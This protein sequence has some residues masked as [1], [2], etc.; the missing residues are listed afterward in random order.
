MKKQSWKKINFRLKDWGVSRQRYWGCPIPIAYDKNGKPKKIPKEM[1][2][3]ELPEINTLDPVGNPLD[4]KNNWKNIII[5]GEN[6]TRET[7]TLDTFVDSSWYFLRF[8]SP[9]KKNYGFDDEA[10]NYWMPVD[11]YIG[12]VEHAILHLLYSRF[13][14]HAISYKN[15]NFN[16]K[17]PFKGLFTQ[18]MVCHETYKDKNNNWLSPE[19]TITINGKKFLKKDPSQ[20]VISGPS[21][22]MSKSKKNTIDPENIIQAYGA[23]S[24]RLFILSDSPPAKDVQWSEEGMSASFKF[25]NKLWNLNSKIIEKINDSVKSDTD[26]EIETYTNKF[27]KRMENNLASFSYNV[28]IASLHE[29]NTFLSKAIDKKY[30]KKTLTDNYKKILITLIPII[31]HFAYECLT[32]LGEKNKVNWPKFNEDIIKDEEINIVI[33]INGKKRSLI[34]TNKNIDEKRLI[35]LVYKDDGLKKYISDKEILKKIYVKNRLMNIIVK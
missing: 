12:G 35:E 34:K 28:V 5:N 6:L 15:K 1:L 26:K 30:T 32:L 22:S 7:D 16:L 20:M 29:M 13:F 21:E 17:E 14:M 9:E 4:K 8:C 11:Q 23:D 18:G 27:I 19:E 33:Q 10:V 31:P 25:I 2:P 24:V 3:V